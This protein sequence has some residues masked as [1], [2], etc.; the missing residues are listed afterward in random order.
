MKRLMYCVILLFI[1][2]A[3]PPAFGASPLP[4]FDEEAVRTYPPYMRTGKHEIEIEQKEVKTHEEYREG[5]TGTEDDPAFFIKTIK[6]TGYPVLD[7]KGELRAI[8]A[9]Y[10]GRSV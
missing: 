10:C 3:V 5:N 1:L 2:T 8:T 7:E 4:T 6:L 9:K